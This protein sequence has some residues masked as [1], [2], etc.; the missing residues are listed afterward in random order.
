VIYFDMNNNQINNEC[1]N[2]IIEF[3]R[4]LINLLENGKVFME[5]NIFIKFM[6][7]YV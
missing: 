6:E 1:D 2:V 3:D 5:T 4:D 7:Y